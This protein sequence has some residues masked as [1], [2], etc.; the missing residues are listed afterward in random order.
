MDMGQCLSY[1][2]ALVEQPVPGSSS[3]R[4]HAWP[5]YHYLQYRRALG[6]LKAHHCPADYRRPDSSLNQFNVRLSIQCSDP[7]FATERPMGAS[8]TLVTVEAPRL[9]GS[10]GWVPD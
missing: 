4:Q 7:A 5:Y 9:L 3:G 8:Q 2:P 1:Q 10:L 6:V